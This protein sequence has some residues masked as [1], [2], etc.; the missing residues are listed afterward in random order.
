MQKLLNIGELA[1]F[2]GFTVAAVSAH[3]HRKNWDAVPKPIKLGR[4][5]AWPVEDVQAWVR[6]K[7]QARDEQRSF[8]SSRAGRPRRM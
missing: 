6:D 2:L 3:L 5:L 7:I 4:R 8:L 1:D